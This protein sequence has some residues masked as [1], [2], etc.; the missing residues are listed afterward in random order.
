MAS[1]TNC[2][3]RRVAGV[4]ASTNLPLHRTLNFRLRSIYKQSGQHSGNVIKELW[5]NM[6]RVL[7]FF[8]LKKTPDKIK[9]RTKEK[10]F[11]YL[12]QGR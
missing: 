11:L 1:E 5:Q 9:P 2:R 4:S 6:N 12:M 8:R 10:V 3:R 7:S